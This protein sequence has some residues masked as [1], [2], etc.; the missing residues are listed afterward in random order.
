MS[1]VDWW[2]QYKLK[3]IQTILINEHRFTVIF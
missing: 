2:Y 3:L 1:Y